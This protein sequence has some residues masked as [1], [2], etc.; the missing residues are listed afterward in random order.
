VR[1]RGARVRA[2]FCVLE[3]LRAP[4]DTL[5]ATTDGDAPASASSQDGRGIMGWNDGPECNRCYRATKQCPV[6]KGEG[7]VQ[8]MFGGCTECDGTGWVCERD[9]RYWK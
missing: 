4:I 2:G 9:G 6:C 5:L 7:T 1:Q 8:Y 3:T